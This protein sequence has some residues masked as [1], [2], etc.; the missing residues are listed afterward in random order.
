MAFQQIKHVCM[1]ILW[2]SV[3]NFCA[4][5]KKNVC[6]IQAE[7]FILIPQIHEKDVESLIK[8]LGV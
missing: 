4:Y 1:Q 7:L 2:V 5:A 6:L 3:N 8:V